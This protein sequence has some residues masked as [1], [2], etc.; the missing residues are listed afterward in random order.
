MICHA[1]KGWGNVGGMQCTGNYQLQ[2]TG[3]AL[4]AVSS[5]T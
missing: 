1:G 2:L 4:N 5:M 3:A